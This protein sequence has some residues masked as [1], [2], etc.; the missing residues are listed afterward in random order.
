MQFSFTR[1]KKHAGQVPSLH[2]IELDVDGQM[3]VLTL[4]RHVRARRMTLKFNP[5]KTGFSITLPHNVNEAE[6]RKF[7]QSQTGWISKQLSKALKTIAF[8][9]GA[10]IPVRGIEHVIFHDTDKRGTVWTDNNA[11]PV[12]IL[13]VS[14]KAPH[15]SRR[16]TDWLKQE[17]RRTLSHSVKIHAQTMGLAYHRVSVRDQNSRWGSCSSNGTLSFSWRLI[18]APDFVLEYVAAHEVAHLAHMNHGSEFW[19]LVSQ[20]LPDMD[21]AKKWLKTHGARLH[22]YGA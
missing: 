1:T 8:A 5:G 13:W 2:P 9:P 21:R 19:E 18:L 14:G 4:K 17:A 20:A 10:I 22:R 3:V 11:R 6:A 15:I 16:L 7:A 12:P